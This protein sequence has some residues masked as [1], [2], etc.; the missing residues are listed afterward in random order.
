MKQQARAIPVL[1]YHHVSPS[2][3]MITV[4]PEHFAEQMAYLASAGYRT[5]G[6]VQLAAF[7]RGEEMPERSFVIT[8]D[9]GYLDNWVH[10]HPVL[11][12]HGFTALC[13]LVSSWPGDGNV[14]PNAA[15]APAHA[16]PALLD[17]H[18]GERAIEE[19]RADD[20]ILRW[21]EIDAMRHAG[22]FEFHSHTHTH[23]RWDQKTASADE[24]RQRLSEDLKTSR[25]TLNARLGQVSD[26]LCWPQGY[27]DEDYREVALNAGFSHFYTCHPG[28]NSRGQEASN[29]ARGSIRRLEVRDRPAS[30]LRSRMWVHSRPLVS[31]AYLSVKR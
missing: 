21:S 29:E 11:Q 14:R 26:H 12:R 1:M 17:H 30:W 16:L 8:F 15:N 5:I 22:T 19:G 18:A 6:A 31:R 2:P 10:A 20:T 28:T 7:L 24:K 23:V 3:G 9:D 25:A 4:K 27:Y 13:F